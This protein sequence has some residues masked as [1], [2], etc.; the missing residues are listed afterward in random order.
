MT[1]GQQLASLAKV[2]LSDLKGT[3]TASKEFLA[4]AKKYPGQVEVKDYTD[5]DLSGVQITAT[6]LPLGSLR[7]EFFDVHVA[8]ALDGQRD[9]RA[10]R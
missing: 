5:G 6:D 3:I 1:R 7:V 4:L 10:Y 8:A 9:A 2:D